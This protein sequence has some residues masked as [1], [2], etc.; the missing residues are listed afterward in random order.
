MKNLLIIGAGSSGEIL[1]KEITK[2]NGN[3]YNIIGFLDNDVSKK[4][5]IINGFKVFGSHE[6]IEEYI[7][8]YYIDEVI[9]AITSIE[10]KELDILY[11]RIKKCKIDVR[12]LPSFEELLLD[13]PFTKQLREVKVEDLLG[14]E[15]SEELS[16]EAAKYIKNK[17]VFI[18]GA[19]GS[20]GSELCRQIVKYGPEKMVLLDINENDL[21]LLELFLKRHYNVSIE[22][23]IC[24]IR[25]MDKVE[26]LFDLYKPDLVFHAAAHKHVPLMEKNIE[27]A[28]KNNVFGTNNLLELSNKYNVD[29][30]VLI[31]TDKAV[32]PTNIMGATKRLSELLLERRNVNSKTKCMAVRFG[33]VLGS[34]GSVIPIFKNLIKE[35]KNLT[36]THSE[37]TRY[38]MTIPEAANLV[39]EAGSLGSGGEVFVLDMGNPVKIIDLAK[40]MIDLSGLELGKDIEI[41][42]S[43]L[44]P[45]EKL[46]EELL[47]DVKCCEKTQNKKIFIAKLKNEN[48]DLSNGL[49]DLE[50]FC[51]NFDRSNLKKKLKELVHTYIEV[52]YE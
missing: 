29:K 36:V 19:A 17:K 6:Y 35:L 23:E 42:I 37:I 26:F 50:K 16:L 38:F 27:E 44:R 12:I 47:Y 41:E 1:S 43:G 39:L 18:T 14:R 49:N 51:N 28:V 34:N 9:I 25:E 10:H 4:G 33:N 22:S 8:E 46:Y 45:G 31:S 15:I 20:I 21:Y 24:N 48:I 40:K 2:R 7:E 32:N 30:F 5:K 13:E 11:K 52:K 3:K